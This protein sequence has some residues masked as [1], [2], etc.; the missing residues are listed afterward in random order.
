M[1]KRPNETGP[2][3]PAPQP[4]YDPPPRPRRGY[5]REGLGEAMIKSF[6]RAIGAS[7]GRVITRTI[8]GRRR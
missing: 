4:S 2:R 5:Q 8:L 1:T 7:L 3:T 6:I